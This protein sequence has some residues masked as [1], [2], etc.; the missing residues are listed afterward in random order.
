MAVFSRGAIR[1]V[2]R[3]A[4]IPD[5][6]PAVSWNEVKPDVDEFAG[7]PV[8]E[9]VVEPTPTPVVEPEPDPAP[10]VEPVTTPAP[11]PPFAPDEPVADIELAT[12]I[13]LSVP[14]TSQAP[15]GVW[16]VLHEDTCEEAAIFMVV[17][18]YQGETVATIDQAEADKEL[19]RLVA[20]EDSFGMGL[21]ITAEQTKE[22]IEA[23]Y[24]DFRA[25]LVY[26][27]TTD[28]LKR[29]LAAGHPVVVPAAGRELGNPNFSGEGPL[30][31]MYVLRGYTE[32]GF[33][34]NDPGTRLG[35]EYFYST[36]VVMNA[37]RDWNNGD[38]SHGARVVVVI[39]PR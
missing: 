2:W 38:V 34:S 21:S 35:R 9:P 20:L 8:V 33:I 26:N 4:T 28:D 7:E 24:P 18:Y 29:L 32:D 10:I 27:P 30:Y 31:H 15:Y 39:Y 3:T 17:R 25:E 23:A 37:I 1:E 36:N 14:F 5:L 11:T 22:V 6:P 13:N 12:S 16:D 19:Y